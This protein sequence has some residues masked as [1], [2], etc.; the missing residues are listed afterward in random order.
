VSFARTL[1]GRENLTHSVGNS[2]VKF[3]S[4]SIGDQRFTLA[5]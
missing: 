1:C 3:S 5:V 4:R 2:G